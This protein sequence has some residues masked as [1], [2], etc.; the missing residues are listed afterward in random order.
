MDVRPWPALREEDQW[1]IDVM[2][3]QLA[4]T[5]QSVE[6]LRTRAAELRAQAD[7]SEFKGMTDASLALADRYEQAASARSTAG[8]PAASG[9]ATDEIE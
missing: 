4:E 3:R 7:G 2:E 8:A 1:L 6:E 5:A 9:H